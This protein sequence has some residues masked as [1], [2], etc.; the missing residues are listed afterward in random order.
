MNNQV[1]LI[2]FLIATTLFLIIL[3]SNLNISKIDDII[4]IDTNPKPTTSIPVINNE[5]AIEN[6]VTTK[7]NFIENFDE[8]C[9]EYGEWESIENNFFFKRSAVFY[10]IDASF[11][12]LNLV[13]NSNTQPNFILTLFIT[14]ENKNS[15]NKW[16]FD[17]KQ[18]GAYLQ[19]TWRIDEYDLILMNVGFN[20]TSFLL[21]KSVSLDGINLGKDV[22]IDIFIE[23]MNSRQ[24]TRLKLNTKLKYLKKSQ[25][26]KP[27]SSIVCSKCLYITKEGYKN[28]EWWIEV[29]KESGYDNVAF[30]NHTISNDISFINLFNKHKDY[31]HIT[32]LR[33]VPN[34]LGQ[35]EPV[36]YF[37][38]FK[39]LTKPDRTFDIYKVEII[40]Q[41]VLTECYLNY[42]DEYKYISIVDP[43]EAIL[44]NKHS[45]YFE[46]TQTNDLLRDSFISN[47]TDLELIKSKIF[48]NK[49]ERYKPDQSVVSEL[50]NANMTNMENYLNELNEKKTL[51]VTRSFYFGQGFFLKYD[52]VEKI[53][54]TLETFFTS[55]PVYTIGN[56]FN[57]HV[58]DNDPF[59]QNKHHPFDYIFTISN[60]YEFDYGKSMLLLYRSIIQPYVDKNKGIFSQYVDDF[61]RI[62][63]ITGN[64]ND[65]AW[66]KSIHN[67][68]K[69]FD[70]T[71]HHATKYINETS[72]NL[73]TDNAYL[74]M[75]SALYYGIPYNLA[76]LSHFRTHFHWKFAPMTITSINIDL[77][78]LNCYFRPIINRLANRNDF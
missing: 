44:I 51:K 42:I 70:L 58:V 4:T 57:V 64:V 40:N 12:R 38:N 43:D 53:F 24:K 48:S 36:K 69:T 65:F 68:S 7:I 50:K 21:D 23:D 17:H 29:S 61:D 28:F 3:Y 34:L 41:M 27:K 67:T 25:N 15:I 78:Y 9:D 72:T 19:S 76:H 77:N 18:D 5:K 14:V 2:I 47:N 56:T 45:E 10:F 30:C 39:K 46:L 55:T 62:F 52:I 75:K 22:R 20:L 73:Y 49:C 54:K 11:F 6:N 16:S 59:I 37:N 33:C 60:I 74:D 13:K 31:L 71:I 1:K 35:S 66:G 26:D 32:E 8:F 63:F